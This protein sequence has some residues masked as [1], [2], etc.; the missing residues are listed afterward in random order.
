[1]VFYILVVYFC[2]SLISQ[3]FLLLQI[4]N[5]VTLRMPFT[6]NH[7]HGTGSAKHSSYSYMTRALR[8]LVCNWMSS[9]FAKPSSVI[10]ISC[11]RYSVIAW[12]ANFTQQFFA[13]KNANFKHSIVWSFLLKKRCFYNSN[14][15]W[16][17][18]WKYLVS[19]VFLLKR[20]IATPLVC[21]FY[22]KSLSRN[23]V[24]QSTSSS[25]YRRVP[26]GHESCNCMTSAL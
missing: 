1:M 22:K 7:Y 19:L 3:V 12:N 15:L 14:A 17:Q 23:W 20:F 26:E 9:C 18:I 21:T 4:F 16:L 6:R 8:A 25:S 5:T 2:T 13:I 24:L 10:M 11:K